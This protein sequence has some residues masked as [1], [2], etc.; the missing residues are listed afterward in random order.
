MA[1]PV[2]PFGRLEPK[3]HV[4]VTR[5]QYD[6]LQMQLQR[7]AAGG[8]ADMDALVEALLLRSLEN[9]GAYN[10]DLHRAGA[11]VELRVVEP[12]APPA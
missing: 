12:C 11:V 8:P 1:D 4:N 2:S 3:V 7:A 5:D 6:A 10:P 9:G